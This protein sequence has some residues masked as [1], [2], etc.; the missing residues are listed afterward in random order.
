V[1]GAIFV[2]LLVIVAGLAFAY[3]KRQRR[4]KQLA[5]MQHNLREH[6]SSV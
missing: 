1:G 3:L 5:A 2:V 4:R 6:A